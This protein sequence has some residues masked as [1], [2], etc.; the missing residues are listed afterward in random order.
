M[1][2]SANKDLMVSKQDTWKPVTQ[3]DP[4]RE[5]AQR[6]RTARALAEADRLLAER[7]SAFLRPS[8]RPTLVFA[9]L[10]VSAMGLVFWLSGG[11]A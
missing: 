7:P 4:A 6:A 1:D 8:A 10:C 3:S 2:Y 9:L 5:A 11:A